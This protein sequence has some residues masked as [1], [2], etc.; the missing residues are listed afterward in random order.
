MIVSNNLF[1]GT[2]PR[3]CPNCCFFNNMSYGAGPEDSDTIVVV[4]CDTVNFWGVDPGIPGGQFNLNTDYTL[5]PG[6]PAIGAATD[7]TD[8]GITGAAAPLTIGERP[9]GPKVYSLGVNEV[10]IPPDSVF[11][12]AFLAYSNMTPIVP[13]AEYEYMFDADL[14]VGTGL[15]IAAISDTLSMDTQGIASGLALGP[16]LFGVRA[17]D[18]QGLW[19]H[20]RWLPVNICE[21]YGPEAAFKSFRSG[22]LV[23]FVDESK[24]ATAMIY[25][26]GDGQTS[27]SINPVHQYAEAGL[28][29]AMQVTT[30]GCGIDTAYR[31]VA[32]SGLTGIQPRKA[33]N[34]GF[35]TVTLNGAGFTGSM[36]I[37][38]N[39][40]GTTLVPLSMDVISGSSALAE[41]DLNGV[42]LGIWDVELVIPGDTTH[43]I[44]SGFETVP[45]AWPRQIVCTVTG[46]PLIRSNTWTNVSVEVH[47]PNAN[48]V[49]AVPVWFAFPANL[50]VELVTPVEDIVFPGSDTLQVMFET[51]SLWGEPYDGTAYPLVVSRIPAFS[52]VSLTF[53]AYTTAFTGAADLYAWA[54]R[55]LLGTTGE[56]SGLD[57]SFGSAPTS[58]SPEGGG[59]AWG[60]TKCFLDLL[61][62]LPGW[63]CGTSIGGGI[64]YVAGWT[65]VNG[66]RTKMANWGPVAAKIAL[67]CGSLLLPSSA[68]L[69]YLKKLKKA[70]D[71]GDCLAQQCLPLLAGPKRVGLGCACDPNDKY[72]PLGAGVNSWISPREQTSYFIAFE[73]VDSSLFAAQR[74]LIHDTLDTDVFDISAA[75]FGAIGLADSLIYTGRGAQQIAEVLPL[76]SG[77]GLRLNAVIDT[78]AGVAQWDLFIV[79]PLNDSVPS[80]PSAG[81]LPPNVASP[82]GQGFVILE[83]P[84]RAGLP[85][86]S[87]IENKATII[88]DNNPSITTGRWQNTLDTV[89]PSSHVEPLPSLTT[90]STV[91][92]ALFEQDQG[93][94]VA[95]FEVYISEDIA[96][97]Y[98]LWTVTDTTAVSFAGEHGVTYHFYSL[99][100][101]SVGNREAKSDTSEA[102]TYFDLETAVRPVHEAN[103][104][105]ISPNPTSG[106][107]HIDVTSTGRL[108]GPIIVLNTLGQPIPLSA[109]T[110]GVPGNSAQLLTLDVSH[111]PKGAYFVTVPTEEGSLHARFV[112]E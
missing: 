21:T 106:L 26:F 53:R 70:A 19:S 66:S 50:D 78:L 47:N 99:A 64:N 34:A 1:R 107:L 54:D 58:G 44:A 85:H 52:T 91:W 6:S 13:L 24:H 88:F 8:I 60:C 38:L 105:R 103:A 14:G 30:N 61:P 39:R 92:L 62:S 15:T 28:F 32:I 63:S 37:T 94:G 41:F 101:D 56:E 51:D 29:N 95:W 17:R 55:P 97:G 74:V 59:S 83:L 76:P 36:A 75:T 22:R 33:G 45:A 27:M 3:G 25:D 96:S 98:Q 35:C 49:F 102:S 5:P 73:N 43:V 71:F 65:Q 111:L 72:G 69:K 57:Q 80:D 4:A 90:D 10:A 68:I 77:Y 12:Y 67:D 2:G 108:N 48:D 46:P 7:G 93:C 40:Q 89:A 42:D 16:H 82:E 110:V 11:N 31:T 86:G 112:K 18:E 20:T 109:A 104:L 23:S 81:F 87:L 100:I 84:L 9:L 79:D